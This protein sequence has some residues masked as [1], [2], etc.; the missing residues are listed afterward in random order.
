LNKWY[1]KWQEST[2]YL[3]K[4]F[5]KTNYLAGDQMT[6]AD[7]LGACEMMQPICAGYDIDK[8]N[9]PKVVDWFE[10]V[11]SKTQPFF[12]EAHK[13][14]YRIREKV[15]EEQSNVKQTSKI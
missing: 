9:Y 7:L 2:G 10:R 13:L 12:D 5:L 4:V 8:A 11:K 3:E 14:N 1:E 6:F 15:V